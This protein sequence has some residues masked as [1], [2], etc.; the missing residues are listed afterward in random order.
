M[1]APRP[2]LYPSPALAERA[3]A[4]IYHRAVLYGV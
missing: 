1:G 2:S 4:R 3:P